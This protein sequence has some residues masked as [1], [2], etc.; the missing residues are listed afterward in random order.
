[1]ILAHFLLSPAEITVVDV[2]KISQ[3]TGEHDRERNIATDNQTETRYGLRGTDLGASFEH[4]GKMVF[5]F[6]DTHPNGGNTPDR[7]FDG[8]AVAT[9]SDRNPDDGLTMEF[10][11]ASDGKYS[12]AKM[13]SVSLKGFEVPNGGFSDGRSMYGYFTTDHTDTVVMGRSVL[14]RSENGIDWTKLYDLSTTKF[15]NVAPAV[16][17]TAKVPGLPM[18]KGQGVLMWASGEYR[19]SSPHLAFVPL[20]KVEDKSA[21]RYWTGT[22]W[23]KTED[24][25]KPLFVHNEIG[26]ISVA[27]CEPLKRWLMT[28]NSGS[29]RGILL[30]TA[31]RPSGPW[32]EPT[33]LF[34]PEK[35]Y[36]KFI[37]RPGKDNVHDARRE[38]EHGG[39]YGPYM[40]PRFFRKTD[41]GATIYFLMSI[42]NPYQ[43]VLMRADLERK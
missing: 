14:A 32:S 20:D 22:A 3:I 39:E 38:N 26:E 11:K 15:I 36:G 16:V 18:S 19:R 28:Y 8:D 4:K 24:E 41:K 1:M 37:H 17:D 23:A 10:L 43:V 7:P 29:P 34:D 31:E 30:R 40:I 9:S 25:A 35:G 5:L 42:W 33:V 21:I 12:A 13:P 6:G 2:R 27:W